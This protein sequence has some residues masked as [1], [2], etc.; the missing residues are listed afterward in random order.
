MA[1]VISPRGITKISTQPNVEEE[2]NVSGGIKK[3]TGTF[4]IHKNSFIGDGST[5]KLIFPVLDSVT[6][7]FTTPV[8]VISD[9]AANLI[10]QEFENSL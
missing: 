8:P 7:N 3:G 5:K 10:R 6:A 1:Y 9:K 2:L 4:V